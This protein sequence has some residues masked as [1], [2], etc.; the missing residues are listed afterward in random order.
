MYVCMYSPFSLWFFLS[1]R[2][3]YKDGYIIIC[4]K[5]NITVSVDAE[6]LQKARE[7]LINVSGAANDA[8]KR[9]I[10][11]SIKDAPVECLKLK[12]SI[13]GA[14]VDFGYFCEETNRITCEECEK[15]TERNS[16]GYMI[17]KWPC[18]ARKEHSHLRLPGLNG[19]NIEILK[20]IAVKGDNE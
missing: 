6:L 3:I 5:T 8:L 7:K 1:L 19:E 18:K 10:Y 17:D 4:M 14:V 2:Y 12:C 16:A 15:A 9:K 13:C 20:K 11:P